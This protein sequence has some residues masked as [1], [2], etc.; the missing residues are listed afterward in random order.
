MF[1]HWELILIP[2]LN[3]FS[4]IFYLVL[5]GLNLHK[6]ILKKL[7]DTIFEFEDNNLNEILALKN[8]KLDLL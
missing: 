8:K 5:G 4:N 1:N 2:I 3:E 7:I 6:I